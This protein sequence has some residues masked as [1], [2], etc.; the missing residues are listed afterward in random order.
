M[1]GVTGANRIE[2]QSQ[3]LC[4]ALR[5]SWADADA[6]GLVKAC[7]ELSQLYPDLLPPVD[8]TQVAVPS[9]YY[10]VLQIDYDA[11]FSRI[12]A[13][14]LKAIKRF[15]R[16]HPKLR[17]RKKDFYILLNAGS[18]LRTPRSRLSH[19]LI[20]ARNALIDAGIIPADGTLE[21]VEAANSAPP[22]SAEPAQVTSQPP[23]E[24]VP[25][26]I[27]L[28]TEAQIIGAAEVQA[29]KNQMR[30]YPDISLAELVLHAGY[31]SAP[32]MKNLQ[33]AEYLISSGQIT[34]DQFRAALAEK[35]TM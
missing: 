20:L 3:I 2:L 22:A 14:Y 34:L 10:D 12:I 18:I 35:R 17:D 26:L 15:L 31:V 4:A 23:Q 7:W 27:Q 6:T 19:D 1:S 9:N 21:L 8:N 11:S 33:M 24:A 5:Q 30:I 13:A 28:L 25:M 29:L 16:D 32:E